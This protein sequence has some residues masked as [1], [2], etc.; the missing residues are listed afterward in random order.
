M[1]GIGKMEKQNGDIKC[2]D[3]LSP[4]DAA[5]NFCR[6]CGAKRSDGDFEPKRNIMAPIYGPPDAFRKNNDDGF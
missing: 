3:C 2:A 6:E 4:M 5:D 1:K